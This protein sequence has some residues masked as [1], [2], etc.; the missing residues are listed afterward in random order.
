M[1]TCVSNFTIY[2]CFS[3]FTEKDGTTNNNERKK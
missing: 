3:M 2:L 1:L